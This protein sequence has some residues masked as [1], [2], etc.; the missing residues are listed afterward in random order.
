MIRVRA[1]I[2][3]WPDEKI[4]PTNTESLYAEIKE[5]VNQ[6]YFRNK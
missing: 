1:G 4:P 2:T 3:N 6:Q 5:T